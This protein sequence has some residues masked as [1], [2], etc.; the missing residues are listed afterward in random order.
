MFV[1]EDHGGAELSHTLPPEKRAA[2]WA[3]FPAKLLA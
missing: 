1:Q 2:S 3:V